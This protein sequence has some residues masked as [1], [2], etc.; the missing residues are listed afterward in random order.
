MHVDTRNMAYGGRLTAEGINIDSFVPGMRLG[1]FSGQLKAEGRGT[2]IYSPRTNLTAALDVSRFAV[3]RR[4]FSGL[5][6]S[7]RLVGGV[8]RAEL[9]NDNDMVSGNVTLSAIM[10]RKKVDANLVCNL[11][12]V[13]FQKL[14]ITK[15]PFTVSLNS[16]LAL[17][18]DLS[19]NYKLQGVVADINMRDSMRTYHPENVVAELLTRTDTTSASISCG[20]FLLRLNAHGG[21]KRLM[22]HGDKVLAELKRQME[23]KYIDQLRLRS[24]LPEMCLTLS[25]SKEN[26][27]TRMLNRKGMDF[28][29]T[30]IDMDVSPVDGI[31]G[32]VR[33]D[34]LMASGIQL[35]TLRLDV[36]SDSVKTVFDGRIANNR[37]NPQYVFTALFG[38]ALYERGVFFGTRVLDS[39]DRLG[40]SS[41]HEGRHGAGRHTHLCRRTSRSSVRL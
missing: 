31:N 35:D 36:K 25:A 18:T 9:S 41:R 8:A 39:H 12:K 16:R 27:F 2:D 32:I 30:F 17:A 13:D 33:I 22:R 7:V 21:Y 38:G 5:R 15:K 23:Q 37:H 19:D 1:L 24:L 26:V 6:A 29:S 14:R 28:K 10:H 11:A 40:R 4:D 20:D 34:S 3:A